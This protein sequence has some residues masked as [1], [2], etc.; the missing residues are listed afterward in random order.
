[1]GFHH[2]SRNPEAFKDAEEALEVAQLEA[3]MEMSKGFS[4]GQWG[5][6]ADCIGP[7]AE[8][9]FYEIAPSISAI[10]DGPVRGDGGQ[11]YL[12]FWVYPDGEDQIQIHYIRTEAPTLIEAVRK[13]V[14]RVNKL[15][16]NPKYPPAKFE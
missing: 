4:R 13:A 10:P 11:S 5:L 3:E 16:I 8:G 9:Y 6:L 7:K 14:E 12:T 1:M 2:M 15:E